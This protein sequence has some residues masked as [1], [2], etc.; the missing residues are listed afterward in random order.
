VTDTPLE[1][2]QRELVAEFDRDSRGRAVSRLLGEYCTRHGD[3]RRHALFDGQHYTRNLVIRN[4]RF[5]MLVLCW[6]RGQRSPIHNHAGQSC[7]MA[8]LDGEI[9][10]TLYAPGV[11]RGEALAETQTKTLAAGRVAFIRDEIALHRVMPV[12]GG[13]GVSLHLYSKPIDVCNVYDES[14]GEVVAKQLEYYSIDGV[15][16]GAR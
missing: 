16:C 8:V 4:E 12:A 3:W 5:E 15:R 7:W 14:S 11:R 10:E 6:S 1:V 13:Q 2:L 9:Q